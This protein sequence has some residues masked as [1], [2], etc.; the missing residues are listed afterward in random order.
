[1]RPIG[2]FAGNCQRHAS[3]PAGFNRQV[4]ALIGNESGH[5]QRRSLGSLRAGPEETRVDG[6]VHHCGL[7]IIV[8]GDP[9]RNIMR[10]SDIA[11]YARCRVPVPSRERRHRRPHQP[12]P[13]PPDSVRPEVRIELIPRVAD[14]RQAI[15]KM[16][17][18]T[19]TDN[20]LRAT[21][22]EADDRVE[23]IEVE[24]LDSRGE[25]RK[26]LPVVARDQRQV[27][28]ER[29]PRMQP[30]DGWRDRTRRV[31]KGEERRR[32]EAF[33]QDLEGLLS[34]PHAGEPI[35]HERQA[36]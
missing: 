28:D 26:I 9:A 7:A 21:V 2:T 22:A 23:V 31:H 35:V 27:L 34:A 16:A 36:H 32:G 19:G 1:V 24:L 8:S 6:R 25:Q 4:D 30:L 33:A 15:T 29:H 11:V 13:Q 18:M 20:R 14:G 5:N 12:A 3:Q 17:R 10:N